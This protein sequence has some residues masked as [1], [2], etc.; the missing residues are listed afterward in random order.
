MEQE[1]LSSLRLRETFVMRMRGGYGIWRTKAI[2]K[3]V[4]VFSHV[5]YLLLC[6]FDILEVLL[7]RERL[8]F[9]GLA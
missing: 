4:T 6:C 7:A 2:L 1:S 8:A 5:S 3:A 9:P